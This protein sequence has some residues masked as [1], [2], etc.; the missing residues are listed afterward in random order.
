MSEA[1][2]RYGVVGII[3]KQYRENIIVSQYPLSSTLHFLIC[4]IIQKIF[5]A[6]KHGQTA[7]LLYSPHTQQ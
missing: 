6:A 3:F 5:T 4:I 7:K 1:A 2:G